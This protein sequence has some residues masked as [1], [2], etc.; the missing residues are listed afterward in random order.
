MDTLVPDVFRFGAFWF[1]RRAGALFRRDE[2]GTL[3]PVTIGS[4]ALAV[5]DTLVT[6]RDDLVSKEEIMHA[7]WPET[8][9]EDNNLTVQIAALRRLL[10]RDRK[11]GSCI[12]TIPGRGYRLYLR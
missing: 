11:Q 2:G 7:V 10:D 1:D 3:V 8:V 4:R 6:R 9:V 5:L 12:Q